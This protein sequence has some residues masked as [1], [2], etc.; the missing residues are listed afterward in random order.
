MFRD[1]FYAYK[2]LQLFD[3]F[4]DFKAFFQKLKNG[5]NLARNTD[6]RAFGTQITRDVY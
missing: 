6:G 5:L 2:L 3:L 1:F 4:Y